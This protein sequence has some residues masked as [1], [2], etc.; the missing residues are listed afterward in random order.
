MPR[1]IKK[2]GGWL[3][4]GGKLGVLY[5]EL[6]FDP[7]VPLDVLLPQNTE[8]GAAFAVAG[9][10][11]TTFD[12]TEELYNHMLLKRQTA[13]ALETAFAEEGNSYLYDYIVRESIPEDMSLAAFRGF[14]SR[15]LYLY[16]K[17]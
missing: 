16:E 6:R 1:L 13:Y 3:K 2:I 7:N 4:P 10:A 17:P 11:Y 5:S 15:F 9:L 8:L 14:Q 12:M